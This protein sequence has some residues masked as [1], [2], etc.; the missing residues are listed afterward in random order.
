MTSVVRG[1]VWAVNF[2]PQT[3]RQEPGKNERPALVIQTDALNKAGS[4]GA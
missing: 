2:E 1:E 4:V 3:H